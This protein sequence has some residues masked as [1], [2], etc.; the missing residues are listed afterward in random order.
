MLNAMNAE[1]IYLQNNKN[2]VN[3]PNMYGICI[4][5]NLMH[6]Q[7]NAI[8]Q[9]HLI[10]PDSDSDSKNKVTF[11]T[12][13][14]QHDDDDNSNPK[15]ENDL[16][17][18][19][20]VQT[21]AP[22]FKC[23]KQLINQLFADAYTS[24]NDHVCKVADHLL[25]DMPR[26]ISTPL[27]KLYDPCLYAA[28][29]ELQTRIYF[30]LLAC[31]KKMN[32]KIIYGDF[33][34]V[35]LSTDHTCPE[36]A[37]AQAHHLINHLSKNKMFQW[38]NIELDK[39]WDRLL[40]VDDRNHC[41]IICGQS[42]GEITLHREWDLMRFMPH[43][44]QSS[45]ATIVGDYVAMLYTKKSASSSSDHDSDRITLLAKKFIRENLTQ[46]LLQS[47]SI[48]QKNKQVFKMDTGSMVSADH[49]DAALEFVKIV[50]HVLC[51]DFQIRDDVQIMK[52]NALK[53]INVK[54]FSR[55]AQFRD[56]RTSFVLPAV[57]CNFCGTCRDL[58]LCRVVDS[59]WKCENCNQSI[60]VHQIEGR[61]LDYV[62]KK[63][64]GYQV[65]D[66]HCVKCGSVCA[67]NMSSRCECSG[68]WAC[69]QTPAQSQQ[70]LILL[71]KI[72][73]RH[74]LA[75]LSETLQWMLNV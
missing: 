15:Q 6:L 23:I 20:N 21:C 50:C 5:L 14:N 65:Q 58:D 47:A 53:L 44:I 2:R 61:L 36:H 41:G 35:I 72:S 75:R 45:F 64:I 26:F 3:N 32:H 22:A 66:L 46:R 25:S 38:M 19:T 39:V 62:H 67:D 55:G 24:N 12:I 60:D 10:V 52:S 56:L 63:M 51:F 33:N 16:I 28:I 49:L 17:A 31:I 54:D 30:Q 4:E 42:A 27:S 48:I 37:R 70:N 13:N 1:E 18:T 34:K 69:K 7:V 29:H 74:G 9:S 57:T 59:D 71:K 73:A 40:W 11:K 68:E 8:I 43:E